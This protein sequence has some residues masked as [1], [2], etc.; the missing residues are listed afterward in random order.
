MTTQSAAFIVTPLHAKTRRYNEDDLDNID[1]AALQK[2]LTENDN[3]KKNDK[4]GNKTVKKKHELS[5]VDKNEFSR[6]YRSESILVV[7]KRKEYEIS[8]EASEDECAA[9]AQRFSLPAIGNLEAE[10]S[11][12]NDSL[13]GGKQG[14]YLGQTMEVKGTIRGNVTQ[15][16]VRTNELFDEEVEFTMFA[17]LRPSMDREISSGGMDDLPTNGDVSSTSPRR[18]NN[19]TK[20]KRSTPA[21]KKH[22]SLEDM[23]MSDLQDLMEDFDLEEDIIEDENIYNAAKGQVDVGELVAQLFAVKLD[24]Y[25]KKPGSKPVNLSFTM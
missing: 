5:L 7:A 22:Q 9:L 21:A 10:L 25:P 19:K 13:G 16:C 15:T 20:N 11:L 4:E 8:I 3:N 23:A 12:K 18:N 24:P 1:L 17:V 14:G 2:S 6:V